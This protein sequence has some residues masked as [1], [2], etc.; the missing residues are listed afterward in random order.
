[1]FAV[2]LWLSIFLAADAPYNSYWEG[3]DIEWHGA[4]GFFRKQPDVWVYRGDTGPDMRRVWGAWSH[5][6]RKTPTTPP[7]IPASCGCQAEKHEVSDSVLAPSAPLECRSAVF[8][9]TRYPYRWHRFGRRSCRGLQAP[10]LLSS[11]P[12]VS[13]NTPSLPL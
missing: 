7:N 9:P 13:A 3:E 6:L 12:T 10:W 8:S 1:M 2:M 4:F 5:D 11:P